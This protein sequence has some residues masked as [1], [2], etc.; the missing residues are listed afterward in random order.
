M[1]QVSSDVGLQN[2]APAGGD[3]SGEVAGKTPGQLFWARFKQD[4][5]AFVGLGVIFL[6]VALALGAGLIA[7][8]ITHRGPNDLSLARQMRDEFGL[9]KGPNSTYIFGADTAGRDLFI[10]VIYGARTSLEVAII[11]TGISVFIGVCLGMT[12]GFFGGKIDTVISRTIDVILSLPLLVFAL[13]I[14]AACGTTKEGCFGGFLKPGLGVVV[15]IIA[16]FSWPYI[17][18][19]VRGNTLSLREK[20]FVEASR[21]L[22]ASNRRI[23]FREVLPNL[24]APILVYSTLII[25]SNI[26]F[27]A[28]LSF[29]GLG[30]PQ[31]TPSWGRMLSEASRNLEGAPWL[32]IFPVLFLVTTTLAF[33][34]LGDGLRDALDPRAG[35]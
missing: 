22:G 30:V 5:V 23:M 20:E 15:F 14:A 35:R 32:M 34:L 33:N 31:H 18:R 27:E 10:R 3:P 13:G 4:R 17:A 8:Y 16:A 19:I 9:P 21:S 1:S 29:L 25:P 11:A 12:A 6:L 26:V 7:H 2:D 24:V 28:A